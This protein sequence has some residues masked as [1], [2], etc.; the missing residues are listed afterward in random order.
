MV[1][2]TILHTR[3]QVHGARHDGTVKRRLFNDRGEAAE[4]SKRLDYELPLNCLPEAKRDLQ[5]RRGGNVKVLGYPL[6]LEFEDLQGSGLLLI[7]FP[8]PKQE[9]CLENRQLGFTSW[10]A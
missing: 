3:L 1:E 10:R 9:V 8:Q 6:I 5:E 7:A 4:V 2:I